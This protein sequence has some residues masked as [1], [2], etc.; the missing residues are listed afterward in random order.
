MHVRRWEPPPPTTPVPRTFARPKPRRYW[1]HVAT[2]ALVM[3]AAISRPVDP[4]ARMREH[5]IA[6]NGAQ[7]LRALL[8][9]ADHD[10]ARV[11]SQA[12]GDRQ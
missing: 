12:G 5:R 3:L 4:G 1:P 10:A 11:V 6:A 8:D 2:V 9:D 7:L